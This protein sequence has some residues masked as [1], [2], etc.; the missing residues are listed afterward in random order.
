MFAPRRDG[1]AIG[2]DSSASDGWAT[3]FGDGPSVGRWR[4]TGSNEAPCRKRRVPIALDQPRII[5]KG[6]RD[7]ILLGPVAARSADALFLNSASGG[8]RHAVRLRAVAA[9]G[10]EGPTAGNWPAAMTDRRYA[11]S[12]ALA[13]APPWCKCMMGRIYGS[14]GHIMENMA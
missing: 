8:S 14:I 11:E 2:V 6:N 5:L 10:D 1:F 3:A 13:G 9:I 4:T 7:S 12:M